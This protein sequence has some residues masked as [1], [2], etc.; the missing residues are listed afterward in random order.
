MNNKSI[1]DSKKI[2]S[3]IVEL[4]L[5]K[6]GYDIKIIYV[7]HLTSLTDIFIICTSNSEPQTRAITNNIKDGLRKHNL[8]PNHIEGFEYLKWVLMDFVNV[9]V[10][11]FNKEYREYYNIE[12]LWGDAKIDSIK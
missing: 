7:D 12:R 2:S 10:N 8:K 6:K 9:T 11:I 5:E 4:I 1:N 3:L